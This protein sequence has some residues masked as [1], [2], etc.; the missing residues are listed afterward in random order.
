MLIIKTDIKWIKGQT[1]ASEKFCMHYTYLKK[2]K[3]HLLGVDENHEW[4]FTFYTEIYVVGGAPI[5]VC[6]CLFKK[7][8]NKT[9]ERVKYVDLRDRKIAG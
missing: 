2:K 5:Y 7:W 4:N 1:N 8:Y 3:V 6:I 9:W